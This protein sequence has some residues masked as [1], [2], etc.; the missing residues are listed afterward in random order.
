LAKVNVEVLEDLGMLEL[1]REN[2]EV[3]DLVKKGLGVQELVKENV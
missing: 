1:V 3:S 2:T